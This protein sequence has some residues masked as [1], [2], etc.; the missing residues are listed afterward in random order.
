MPINLKVKPHNHGHLF[1]GDSDLARLDI[2][3]DP[4]F[5]KL[6]ETDEANFWGLNIVS[7]S[8]DRL[9]EMPANGL[10]KFQKTNAYQLAM[11]STV[12][13]VFSYLSMIST[14][15]W[16]TYLYSRISTMEHVHAMSYSSGVSQ[17]FGARATDFLDILYTDEQI[18]HRVDVE[19]DVAVRF[20]DAV[21]RGWV[22]SDYNKKL[23][24]ELL[25]KVLC[26]EGIKFPF[27]FFT[28]WTLN[29]AFGNVAQGFCQLLLKIANDEMMIHTTTGVSVLSR[30]SKSQKF[31]HLFT[32]GWFAEM[33]EQAILETE[34]REVA[35]SNYLL[36][37][38]EILGFNHEINTHFIK[39]WAN[40][41]RKEIGIP[42]A[43]IKKND[44]E[45]WFDD[46]RNLNAKHSA[47]QEI[48][49]VT[50]QKNTLVN[51]LYK[52]TTRKEQN[53]N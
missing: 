29:R 36:L 2:G 50:Y 32:S 30:L 15:P 37:D 47:L 44:V 41:R 26:L 24:L 12:P 7:C 18:V 31:K 22:E 4:Y 39:Y 13:D 10:S 21:N 42:Y 6:S 9:S 1:F 16:L 28:T 52:F 53:E 38:G 45:I 25:V 33:A 14:D 46:Y 23:L 5:K 3:G 35:W 17:A 8:Q 40:R 20:I 43:D 19:L 27:S 49:S 34:L 51:D 11:D 48:D